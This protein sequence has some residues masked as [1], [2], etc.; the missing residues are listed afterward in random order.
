[1]EIP[2]HYTILGVTRTA[3]QSVIKAAYKALALVHHP[4]K[5]IQM[6]AEER[7]EHS[8][9]FRGIQ[10]AWD[11][12]GNPTLKAAY[13]SELDRHGNRVNPSFSI[14]HRP[15]A[16]PRRRNSIRI[17]SP[18]EKRM[19]VAKIQADMAYLKAQRVKRDLEDASMDAAGLKFMLE[20]WVAMA[21]EYDGEALGDG[22]M[23]AHCG[24]QIQV[25]QAKLEQRK[26]Q[27]T[28]WFEDLSRPK[29]PPAKPARAAPQ[30]ASASRP[31]AATPTG[32]PVPR[33]APAPTAS[34]SAASIRADEKARKEAAKQAHLDAKAAAVRAE[35]EKQKVKEDEITR[36]ESARFN[37]ARAKAGAPPLGQWGT[38]WEA[39]PQEHAGGSPSS[40][41]NTDGVDTKPRREHTGG[42]A[43]SMAPGS[44]DSPS[45]SKKACT[46]CGGV[47]HSSFSEF[48]KC[49]LKSTAA[50]EEKEGEESFFHT[51]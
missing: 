6:S 5:T 49:H 42:L 27:H 21:Q 12:L 7:A 8:A 25:Y 3:E 9:V 51:V 30:N 44:A 23:R 13:D 26:R 32:K 34:H 40:G 28:E 11:V 18:E 45:N 4:D 19:W 50:G 22:F 10:E 37:H 20:T 39:P 35:K 33:A 24:V 14:F 15:S 48:R 38:A 36:Q 31:R 16:V 2:T 17:T 43:A 41:A 1:M 46:Y 29:S 47:A